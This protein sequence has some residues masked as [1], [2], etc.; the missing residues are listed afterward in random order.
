MILA[1]LAACADPPLLDA[2]TDELAQGAVDQ[3]EPPIRLLSAVAGVLAEACSV[4]EIGSYTFTG[5]AARALGISTATAEV[6]SGAQTW[7]FEGV[8]LD[9]AAGDLSVVTDLSRANFAVA[10]RGDGATLSAGLEAAACDG[11]TSGALTG[12]GTWTFGA[13]QST[14]TVL[15]AAPEV[16]LRF[17]PSLAATPSA[18]QL[19]WNEES[20]PLVLL[21]ADASAIDLE[22]GT[23]PGT[24]DGKGWESTVDIEV[25]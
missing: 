6:T 22:A 19:R 20:E 4:T 7:T 1:L 14:L 9:G 24:V 12:N 15:A 13:V 21:L 23:W 18:G 25:P 3:A 10:W 2:V 17:E 5:G 8:G 16:G 11:Q